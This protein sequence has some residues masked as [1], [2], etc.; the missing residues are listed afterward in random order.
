M[1]RR[2]K[3]QYGRDAEFELEFG[4]DAIVEH[5]GLPM[6]AGFDDP[7]AAVM[8]S[9]VAP[10]DFPALADATVPGDRVVV[11]VGGPVPQLDLLL[12]GVVQTLIEGGLSNENIAVLVSVDDVPA[13]ESL[14]VDAWRYPVQVMTHDPRDRMSLAYLATTERGHA[15][16]INRH[17]C[18]AD[19]VVT[20]GTIRPHPTR[21]YFGVHGSVYP[22]FADVDTLRRY[23]T[24]KGRSKQAVT[25]EQLAREVEEAGWLLGA[26]FT[27]QVI[28]AAGDE[29]LHILSGDVDT[30][31]SEGTRLSR[32]AWSFPVTEKPDLVIAALSGGRSQQ[33]WQNV[34]RTLESASHV[35]S[36]NR[37]IV[38]C[39]ELDRA[40]DETSIHRVADL[41]PDFSVTGGEVTPPQLEALSPRNVIPSLA[42]TSVYLLSGLSD[43]SVERMG[44]VPVSKPSEIVN[45]CRQYRRCLVLSNAQHACPELI[46]N[47]V[48]SS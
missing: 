42:D 14:G 41:E 11:A 3:I 1:S 27:I 33:T 15:V 7:A 8:A 44:M 12:D 19:F 17:V 31:R 47:T 16:Y 34:Y 48:S 29:I 22:V 6:G 2:E 5:H 32:K 45:L 40:V 36:D 26:R 25:L 23:Q 20:L 39:T 21:D 30:V 13:V 10:L 9:L 37:A 43:Q 35:I 38:I 24:R 4:D 18:D 46:E 28:P